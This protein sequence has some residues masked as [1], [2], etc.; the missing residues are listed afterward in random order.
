VGVL[1]YEALCGR[2]PFEGDD[3][4]TLAS[5]ISEGTYDPP[6]TVL[7]DADPGIAAVIERAMRR[8]PA[9]RFNSAEEMATTLLGAEAT[10]APIAPAPESPAVDDAGTD[11][12]A[13]KTVPVPRLDQTARLPYQ[14]PAPRPERPRRH[15]RT[16]LIVVGAV[17]AVVLIAV[18]AIGVFT[19]GDAP[20]REP[21]A[22][23]T[24]PA[25]V[26][27]ALTELEESVQP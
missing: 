15:P 19:G 22:A 11:T 10:T 7:P 23:T 18:L 27:D 6:Q 9:G 20:R 14:A 16:I 1:L 24:L 12:G 3:P 8:D 2:R 21:P 17:I 25:P 26:E 5:A 13:T 4:F